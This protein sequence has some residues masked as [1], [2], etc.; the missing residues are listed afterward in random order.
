MYTPNIKGG[1]MSILVVAATGKVGSQVVEQLHKQ[2]AD[3]VAATR[4]PKKAAEELPEGVETVRFDI[5]DEYTYDAALDGTD[6]VFLLST[7]SPEAN[8]ETAP[9]IEKCRQSGVKKMVIMSAMGVEHSETEMRRFELDVINSEMD[10]VIL[11]PNWFYQNFN[12][13]FLG[14]INQ[15][16]GIY[17]PFA[18]AKVSYI[19]TRDIAACAVKG[20]TTDDINGMQFTI[21]GPESLTLHEVA[22]ILSEKAHKEIKYV[23]ITDE[24][25]REAMKNDMG[26]DDEKYLE[27]MHALALQVRGG[28]AAEVT[29]DV[30]KITGNDPVA[31]DKYGND[32]AGY[33]R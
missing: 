32:Y 5:W 16:N 19:D 31:F 4:D 29:D 15:M 2:G 8:K 6:T 26:M 27:L 3:F 9:F 11:R 14:M 33:W 28:G 12:T 20:L 23:P 10:Y 7:Y 17:L 30:K 13:M 21:T 1:R 25:A 18:D 22:D 24:Q